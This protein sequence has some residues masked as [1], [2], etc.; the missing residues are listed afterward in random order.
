MMRT[1]LSQI[2][3]HPHGAIL[4]HLLNT[5]N[6]FL[7][8]STNYF[9]NRL[10][11]NDLIIVTN[12]ED[13]VEDE[14]VIKGALGRQGYARIKVEIQ[15]NSEFECL[16]S[17]PTQSPGHPRLQ[18][19]IQDAY[20]IRFRCSTY[21]RK[22]YEIK[23]P[24]ESQPGQTKVG[25]DQ[26]GQ[27]NFNIQ[28][29]TSTGAVYIKTHAE[30]AYDIK[31]GCSWTPWKFKEITFPLELVPC[32]NSSGI[33]GDHRNNWTSRICLSA[34]PPFLAFG[35][36]IMSSPLGLHLGVLAHPWTLYNQ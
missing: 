13:D 33:N 19:D 24:M 6:S 22:E 30:V 17:S 31:L 18:I 26:N 27:N 12:Y 14:R 28:I 34:G 7:C 4:R 16:A 8:S 5:V 35:P 3:P 11:S 9:E 32:L 36:C 10:L 25:L 20:E 21:A 15:S 29:P 23:F 2:H 1:C